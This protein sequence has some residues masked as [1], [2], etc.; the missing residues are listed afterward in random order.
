MWKITKNSLFFFPFLKNKFTKMRKFPPKIEKK[1]WDSK[2]IS[3]L[4]CILNNDYSQSDEMKWSQ[5]VSL[6]HNNY[7]HRPYLITSILHHEFLF[8]VEHQSNGWSQIGDGHL[9]MII[10][11]KMEPK[12]ATIHNNYF[13]KLHFITLWN[14]KIMGD[15]KKLCLYNN[16]Y[17]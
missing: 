4:W 3:I 5:K 12:M 15:V 14:I 2:V 7:F 8:L 16:D 6:A 13:D 1:H 10:H 9:I 11:K 17:S